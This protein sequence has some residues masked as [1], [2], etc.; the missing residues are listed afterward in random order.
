AFSSLLGAISSASMLLDTS[1][2]KTKSSPSR[3]TLSILVPILGL[4]KASA[5]QAILRHQ[6]QSLSMDLK[7]DLLGLSFFNASGVANLFC[8][9]IFQNCTTL[10]SN[11]KTG[12]AA[13]TQNH[14]FSSS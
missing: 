7:R 2:A 6:R 1:T 8:V 3:F 4:T 10:K 13:K 14:I 9:R 11:T 12:I 5:I